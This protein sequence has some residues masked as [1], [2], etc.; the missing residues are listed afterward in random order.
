[1]PLVEAVTEGV[2]TVDILDPLAAFIVGVVPVAPFKFL[3]AKANVLAVEVPPSDTVTEGVPVLASTVAEAP[4]I[5]AAAPGAPLMFLVV[6]AVVLVVFV[7]LIFPS[8]STEGFQYLNG[9]EAVPVEKAATLPVVVTLFEPST[10]VY[11]VSLL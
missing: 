8:A 9:A 10:L 4:V 11:S 7:Q 5:V 1:M 6:G 2:P 3:K